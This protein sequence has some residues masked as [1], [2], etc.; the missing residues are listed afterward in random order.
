[1]AGSRASTVISLPVLAEEPLAMA[2]TTM[3]A[4]G[5]GQVWAPRNVGMDLDQ[6][7]ECRRKEVYFDHRK[8]AKI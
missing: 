6:I 1:M 4:D 7:G 5:H 3:T 8:T 2:P